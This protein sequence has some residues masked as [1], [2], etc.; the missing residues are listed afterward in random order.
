MSKDYKNL[1]HASR[2]LRELDERLVDAL[3]ET[4]SSSGLFEMEGM[5]WRSKDCDRRAFVFIQQLLTLSEFYQTIN[6]PLSA[7]IWGI[8]NTAK[9]F[10]NQRSFFSIV[11]ERRAAS[12]RDFV[13]VRGLVATAAVQFAGGTAATIVTSDV[14]ENMDAYRRNVDQ[15][16][17]CLSAAAMRP[18]KSP[19]RAR[20]R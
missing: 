8:W 20:Q 15:A 19:E 18:N 7:A 6:A 10:R 4:A 14:Y 11:L 2:E 5:P 13:D 9:F 1:R 16:L 12:E 3:F 17:A